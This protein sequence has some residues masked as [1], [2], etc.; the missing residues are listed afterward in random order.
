MLHYNLWRFTAASNKAFALCLFSKSKF[1]VEW[2]L[3]FGQNNSSVPRRILPRNLAKTQFAGRLVWIYSNSALTAGRW[4]GFLR[5]TKLHR[6]WL[7]TRPGFL[8]WTGFETSIPRNAF[9]M[10]RKM[11]PPE[12]GSSFWWLE[13]VRGHICRTSSHRTP[14]PS[15][16]SKTV[17]KTSPGIVVIFE[18]A[19]SPRYFISQQ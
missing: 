17:P 2:H 15:A 12:R 5:W 7:S 14:L 19:N 10:F 11:M 16:S 3:H 6:N 13:A 9:W 8:E 4:I 18:I 1:V